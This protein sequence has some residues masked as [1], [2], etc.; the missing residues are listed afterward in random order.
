MPLLLLFSGLVCNCT[1]LLL[2]FSSMK[3]TTSIYLG[4]FC[5]SIHPENK[6][7]PSPIYSGL[8]CVTL[9]ILKKKVFLSSE[10]NDLHLLT[11]KNTSILEAFHM[12][13]FLLIFSRLIY[14]YQFFWQKSTKNGTFQETYEFY[15]LSLLLLSFSIEQNEGRLCHKSPPPL[16]RQ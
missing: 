15:S 7:P 6:R 10:G 8:V 14:I 11:K 2:P 3:D 16:S 12:S 1:H 13:H 5:N 4:L 9:Y